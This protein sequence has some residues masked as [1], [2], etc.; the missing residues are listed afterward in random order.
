[1]RSTMLAG[2]AAILVF[3]CG[4][5]SPTPAPSIPAAPMPQPGWNGLSSVGSTRGPGRVG[6]QVN[7]SGRALALDVICVGEGM[8]VVSYGPGDGGT[9]IPANG[10]DAVVFEC[11]SGV[12]QQMRRELPTTLPAGTVTFTAGIVPDLQATA[13]SAFV[14]A[15]EEAS[16]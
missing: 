14:V 5:P 9:P 15:V 11:T 10:L 7:V 3:G 6:I 13:P 2:F 1:M 12:D 8:L 16:K 4:S